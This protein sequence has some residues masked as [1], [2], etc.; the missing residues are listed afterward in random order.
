VSGP[1]VEGPF[2]YDDGPEPLHT[3]T[4]RRS[5]RYLVLIFGATALLAVLSVVLLPI[6]KGSAGAQSREVVQVF[7][8]ALHKGDTETAYDLL[9]EKERAAVK[10]ED[11][12]A[13]YVVGDG[14]GQVVDASDTTVGGAPAEHV[15]VRW[16]DGSL[17]RFTVV[18]SNGPHVCGVE[19][20]G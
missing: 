19:R 7:L 13:Q 2:L 18:N 3:G 8:A 14:P 15:R 11:V 5:G 16:P 20:T 9:C 1:A 6:L 12:A 17:S 4:P 10:P